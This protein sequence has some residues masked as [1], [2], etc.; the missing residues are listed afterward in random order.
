MGSKGI[1]NNVEEPINK[2]VSRKVVIDCLVDYLVIYK[3]TFLLLSLGV[4]FVGKNM[5]F[6][7][8]SKHAN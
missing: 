7:A 8:L 3:S 6:L 2:K 1:Q 5:R 4:K